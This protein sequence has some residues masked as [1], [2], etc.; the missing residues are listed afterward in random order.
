MGAHKHLT[1]IFTQDRHEQAR[2]MIGVERVSVDAEFRV[3]SDAKECQ[4]VLREV[5]RELRT[6]PGWRTIERNGFD[7]SI[8]RIGPY[9]VVGVDP[10]TEHGVILQDGG[11]SLIFDAATLALIRVARV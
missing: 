9:L 11:S 7:H 3:L 1:R 8:Y 5:I 2:S 10:R 4:P 6:W